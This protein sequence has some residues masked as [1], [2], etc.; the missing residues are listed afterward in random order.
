MTN[1][2]RIEIEDGAERLSTGTVIADETVPIEQG[3]SNR[4]DDGVSYCIRTGSEWLRL[5]PIGSRLGVSHCSITGRLG[6]SL[7]ERFMLREDRY[8]RSVGSH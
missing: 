7:N 2:S 4:S 3:N 5:V 6:W 8:A 1:S